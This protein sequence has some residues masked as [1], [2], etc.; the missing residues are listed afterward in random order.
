MATGFEDLGAV[1][2]PKAQPHGFEDL[3]AVAETTP[4][5]PG[6]P[7]PD[8][9]DDTTSFADLGAVTPKQNFDRV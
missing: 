5:A 9:Q 1:E 4:S 8:A 3:G 2:E 6:L 7:K